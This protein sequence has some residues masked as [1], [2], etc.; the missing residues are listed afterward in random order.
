MDRNDQI[1]QLPLK[2]RKGSRVR[3]LL[4]TEG[5][6]AQVAQRLTDLVAPFATVDADQHC[7]HPSGLADRE[8]VEI[9]KA[10]DL[11]PPEQRELLIGWWLAVRS[12]RPTTPKWDIASTA[13]IAGRAGLL[14]V[15]AKAHAGELAPAGKPQQAAASAN[16][17]QNHE[18]I[19]TAVREA[20][21]AL[22]SIT[23]GW[24]LE[25]TSHYQLANRFAWSWKLAALGIPVVLVY[26][27]FLAAEE[28]TGCQVFTDA[29]AWEQTV[30]QYSQGIVPANV[31]ETPLLVGDVPVYACIRSLRIPLPSQCSAT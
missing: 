17:Q 27:G 29:A 18:R 9:D 26:L 8:E 2:E 5:P 14:L 1:Q 10:P 31:W 20:N 25:A 22:N 6:R 21:T 16:S 12:G 15:E 19:I 4:L 30:R 13:Q 23:P 7:W 3:C 24:N 11:L 28:M